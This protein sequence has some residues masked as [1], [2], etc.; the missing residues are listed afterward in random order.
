MIHQETRRLRSRQALLIATAASVVTVPAPTVSAS[1]VDKIAQYCLGPTA[2]ENRLASLEECFPLRPIPD[3][4]NTYD[5]R[6][7]AQT[8]TEDL[9]QVCLELMQGPPSSIAMLEVTFK[10]SQ[11]W[12]MTDAHFWLGSSVEDAPTMDMYLHDNDDPSAETDAGN[13]TVPAAAR[14]N[15]N[16]GSED[17]NYVTT[18]YMMP[19]ASRFPY[20]TTMED[21][22][23]IRLRSTTEWNEVVEATPETI[24]P[25]G[26]GDNINGLQQ[27]LRFFS[28]QAILIPKA[29][30][31]SSSNNS[32]SPS[33]GG[34]RP[35]VA[36]A[37]MRQEESF[38]SLD[39]FFVA[40]ACPGS[41]VQEEDQDIETET[42]EKVEE[43]TEQDDIQSNNLLNLM[44]AEN[45][46]ENKE[47][48]QAE[49]LITDETEEEL[50]EDETKTD[51]V[52]ENNMLEQMQEEEEFEELQEWKLD[53]N[54]AAGDETEEGEIEDE[55]KQ[56]EISENNMLEKMEVEEQLD[57]L[58]EQMEEEHVGDIEEAVEDETKQDESGENNMLEQMKID[59]HLDELAEE[60]E[61][62]RKA[63]KEPAEEDFVEV[64]EGQVD[65]DSS[66]D[67]ADDVIVNADELELTTSFIVV[68]PNQ[69]HY[70]DILLDENNMHA[71]ESKIEASPGLHEA[72]HTFVGQLMGDFN[73]PSINSTDIRGAVKSEK[74]IRRNEEN[75]PV[76]HRN[77]KTV[78]IEWIEDSPDLFKFLIT[79]PCPASVLHMLGAKKKRGKQ[80]VDM[81]SSPKAL[82]RAGSGQDS[83]FDEATCYKAFGKYKVMHLKDPI[84]GEE[85]FQDLEDSGSSR[86]EACYD[87]FHMTRLALAKGKLGQDLP[88]DVP[89]LIHGGKPE[90][91]LPTGFATTVIKPAGLKGI[92]LT[93]GNTTDD[94]HRVKDALYE[95]HNED[96]SWNVLR[97]MELVAYVSTSM[98]MMSLCIVIYCYFLPKI[99]MECRNQVT[100]DW[101]QP[102]MRPTRIV[103][104]RRGK[105]KA[106]ETDYF[107]WLE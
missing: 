90:S 21:A 11:D 58:T 37:A 8:A 33:T 98:L 92:D 7:D 45:E 87:I 5:E 44:F 32:N 75:D 60:M 12:V 26:E 72:W 88:D 34:L 64:Q 14:S 19:D 4:D 39:S 61:E 80:V 28:A 16:N 20:Y 65:R 25:S 42:A 102:T 43:E 59:E 105:P 69:K 71:T 29:T 1:G 84:D 82:I 62:D 13:P 85:M 18:T 99:D 6:V 9:G 23:D 86:Q 96:G 68:V 50:V 106:K 81:G 76:R 63:G 40:C 57:E 3:D 103:G 36:F 101:S 93:S 48:Q 35:I 38:Q 104:S 2:A 67:K 78:T 24:C 77:L 22:E 79:T 49:E 54:N 70:M 66:E 52:G 95:L 55:T 53:H 83:T 91:C 51:E 73:V 30:E 74:G 100:D 46:E 56:D 31:D 17:E 89:F 10:T 15:T 97:V 107:P 41:L 27:Q 47:E 94:V